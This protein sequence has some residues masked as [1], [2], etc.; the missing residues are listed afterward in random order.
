MQVAAVKLWSRAGISRVN[1]SPQRLQTDISLP[2]SVQ[3]AGMVWTTSMAWAQSVGSVGVVEGEVGALVG[4][5]EGTSSPQA[6]KPS[7]KVSAKIRDRI[8]FI[9]I[10]TFV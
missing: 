5:G 1:S 4:V 2:G 7:T 9:A 10:L 3:L 8:F 6:H